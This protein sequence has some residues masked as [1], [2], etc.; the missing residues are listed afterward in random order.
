[1]NCD[2]CLF[3]LLIM[4]N[5]R[6]NNRTNSDFLVTWGH[7]LQWC[8]CV[9]VRH[10]RWIR[11]L[12]H[13]VRCAAHHAR[14]LAA[15][16][17]RLCASVLEKVRVSCV[18]PERQTADHAALHSLNFAP[19]LLQLRY[20]HAAG[21]SPIFSAFYVQISNPLGFVFLFFPLVIW[22]SPFLPPAGR[23]AHILERSALNQTS[24]LLK[25]VQ[26][27]ELDL[28][29]SWLKASVRTLW[30]NYRVPHLYYW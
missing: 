28:S 24:S 22:R 16:S 21:I 23:S 13:R 19:V 3:W 6:K 18:S 17:L 25:V 8:T 1:M 11:V 27:S 2:I 30:L 12:K 14:L 7:T 10:R 29:W 4:N 9:C 15:S 5:N 20:G 26:F